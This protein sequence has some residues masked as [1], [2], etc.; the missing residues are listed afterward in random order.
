MPNKPLVEEGGLS[1][2]C[3]RSLD[4]APEQG[5]VGNPWDAGHGLPG[6]HIFMT[7]FIAS[8]VA[9]NLHGDLKCHQED[10]MGSDGS[11]QPA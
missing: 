2:D 8:L 3:V 11:D 1:T 5:L 4:Q 10:S 6:L 9:D 7:L